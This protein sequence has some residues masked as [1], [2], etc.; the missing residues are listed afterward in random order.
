M[1]LPAFLFG[2][3]IATLLGAIFH[4]LKGGGPGRL[5]LYVFLS[6]LGFFIGHIIAARLDWNLW[7]IGPLRF[8]IG[9]LGSL[10]FLVAGNWL[11]KINPAPTGK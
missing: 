11:S 1:T 8:G 6:W 9:A 10:F 2:F 4:L 5:F 7:S 3:L